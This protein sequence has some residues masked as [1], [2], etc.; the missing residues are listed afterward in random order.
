ML[1]ALKRI[2]TGVWLAAVTMVL[3]YV[4]GGIFDAI[5]RLPEGLEGWLYRTFNIAD[6]GSLLLFEV[7]YAAAV[8]FIVV[9]IC[10]VA[11]S[12]WKR[13]RKLPGAGAT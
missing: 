3:A 13:H 7:A 10:Y 6:K 4:W 5:P 9:N 2:N 12:L 11:L 1:E 8:S